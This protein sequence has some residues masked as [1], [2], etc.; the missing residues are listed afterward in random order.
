MLHTHNC[1]TGESRYGANKRW[2]KRKRHILFYNLTIEAVQSGVFWINQRHH[3][4]TPN[5][6]SIL[7]K[8]SSYS[9]FFVWQKHCVL[10]RSLVWS[11]ASVLMLR[12]VK[13]A[14]QNDK[15][16]LKLS[17]YGVKSVLRI[18]SLVFISLLNTGGF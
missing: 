11:F 4:K 12:C 2:G 3:T 1:V 6:K 5:G 8:F 9:V 10:F 7:N 14:L 18:S 13:T 16:H 17:S 15:K